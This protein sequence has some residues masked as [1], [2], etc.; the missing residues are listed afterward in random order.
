M[1]RI[2]VSI[3]I[4]TFNRAA[5]FALSLPALRQQVP[6]DFTYEVIFV[7]N[8]STDGTDAI[9]RG[10]MAADPELFRYYWIEPTGGPSAPRNRGIREASG[11]I[12]IILDDDVVPDPELVLR[13]VEF[14]AAHPGDHE[15]AVGETYVPARLMDDPMSLFHS[16]YSYDR[17]QQADR[18]TFF[19]FWT[20]NV[21][22]KRRFMLDH[23]MFDERILWMEDTEVGYRLGQAGMHL[24]YVP[25]ARGQHLHETDPAT[26]AR[27]ARLFGC[28]L[29]RLT[30]YIPAPL[31]K[32]RFGMVTMELGPVWFAK[33]SVRLLGFLLID[34]PLTRLILKQLAIGRE[35]RNRATDAYYN[36]IFY[37]AFIGGYYGT[38][39]HSWRHPAE[40]N[41]S[42]GKS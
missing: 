12:I 17:F 41:A 8:G 25:A 3:V 14:H 29:Y 13:H 2:R 31:L 22:F 37:R 19:D 34:N 40:T 39:F 4:P 10:A 11:E 6:G 15:A 21:S 33:R 27:R 35:T 9:L 42:R 24:Y 5:M 36:L 7:A 38:W 28:W 20:C 18:L 1:S 16:H 30:A 23:G 26:L 32:R